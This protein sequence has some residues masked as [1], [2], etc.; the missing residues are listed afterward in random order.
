MHRIDD[1]GAV[2]GMWTEGDP[3]QAIPATKITDD[4]LN[5]MQE[6]I[7]SFIEAAGIALV[8]GDRTQLRDAIDVFVAAE[9]S[10]RASADTTHANLTN[11]HSATAAATASRLVLR[12]A[13]ARAQFGAPA[14]AGDVA[15][16]PVGRSQQGAAGEQVS[17][18]ATFSTMSATFVDVTNL[19]VTITTSGRPVMLALV[20]D[21]GGSPAYVNAS[22]GTGALRWVR[23]STPI[24]DYSIATANGN[25]DRLPPPHIDVVG[26]G[27]YTYKA[28]MKKSTG[29]DC[30]VGYAKLVAIEL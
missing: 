13:N 25:A 3:G 10:A 9:A 17:A 4:W 30:G 16:Y 18:S 8:K 5:D 26:A 29:T 12:D 19:S 23:G 24:G 7:A 21:A 11:P 28:Q 22:G 14:T 27:T 1:Y 20:S 15:I 6:E 2:A